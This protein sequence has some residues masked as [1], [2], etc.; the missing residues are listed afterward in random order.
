DLHPVQ[1]RVDIEVR[2]IEGPAVAVAFGAREASGL[3]RRDPGIEIETAQRWEAEGLSHRLDVTSRL[4]EADG[5]ADGRV[6]P[7]TAHRIA[8][9]DVVVLLAAEIGHRRVADGDRKNARPA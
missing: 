6:H 8:R 1:H 7:A 4:P 5:Q 9:V 3:G 2:L